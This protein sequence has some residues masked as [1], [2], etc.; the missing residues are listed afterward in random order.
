MSSKII[1]CDVNAQKVESNV[2][3][4]IDYRFFLA[5]MHNWTVDSIFFK[6]QY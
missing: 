6:Y 4:A 3:D 1:W 5:L 2:E